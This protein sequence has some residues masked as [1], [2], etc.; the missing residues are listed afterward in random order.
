[1]SSKRRVPAR[2]ADPT[3]ESESGS[4][5]SEADGARS[6]SPE[7][8]GTVSSDTE[9]SGYS[10]SEGQDP[11]VGDRDSVDQSMTPRSSQG[12]VAVPTRKPVRDK[13]GV[14]NNAGHRATPPTRPEGKKA[15]PEKVRPPALPR[16][17]RSP[18]HTEQEAMRGVRQPKEYMPNWKVINPSLDMKIATFL[19][20]VSQADSRLSEASVMAR[21]ALE[22]LNLYKSHELRS[23]II[24]TAVDHKTEQSWDILI[25]GPTGSMDFREAT[26][27]KKILRHVHA[28]SNSTSADLEEDEK[29]ELG[30]RFRQMVKLKRRDSPPAPNRSEGSRPDK[31]AR[32][33][34]RDP[35]L[36]PRSQ[37]LKAKKQ[38]LEA[39]WIPKQ[40][41]HTGQANKPGVKEGEEKPDDR[42]SAGAAGEPKSAAPV[43]SAPADPIHQRIERFIRRHRLDHRAARKL[44]G[45]SPAIAQKAMEGGFT[46]AKNVSALI[47]SRVRKFQ[48]EAK[49]A[50]HSE[51]VG[52]QGDGEIEDPPPPP[53]PSQDGD[54]EEIPGPDDWPGEDKPHDDESKDVRQDIWGAGVLAY[55]YDQYI[56]FERLSEVDP[57]ILIITNYKGKD[58]FPKGARK[59]KGKHYKR[60]APTKC[61]IREFHEETNLQSKVLHFGR[62]GLRITCRRSRS[63]QWDRDYAPTGRMVTKN[64]YVEYKGVMY[65]CAIYAVANGDLSGAPEN[66]LLWPVHDRGGDIVQARWVPLSAAVNDNS[67]V[68][69]LQAMREVSET[70]RPLTE[71]GRRRTATWRQAE[72]PNGAN[73]RWENR[74]QV[75]P[76][77]LRHP[78]L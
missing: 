40:N 41:N 69:L 7:K 31:E 55:R 64:T 13:T 9:Y 15:G 10:E 39:A 54:E 32:V 33:R 36:S 30:E 2:K 50:T 21:Q 18:E 53:P 11:R 59:R 27:I 43:D 65:F 52:G 12:G 78:T 35:A 73:L 20:K 3:T 4:D 61:A 25:K 17:K 74:G 23:L 16:R 37:A 14:T 44:R 24:D 26:A 29:P 77:V 68:Y 72:A 62:E 42:G 34:K 70:G 67:P 5:Y 19:F 47:T 38:K 22:R 60:E 58:G 51:W 48:E 1:M 49:Q 45:A 56:P 76:Q 46:K 28:D 6:K 63:P 75:M 66:T 8:G 57:Y 71:P